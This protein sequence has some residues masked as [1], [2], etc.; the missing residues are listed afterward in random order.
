M[1]ERIDISEV[2]TQHEDPR[3]VPAR[4]RK[5]G[6]GPATRPHLREELPAHVRRL[7]RARLA[8]ADR[9]VQAPLRAPVRQR[10]P[11][12]GHDRA[13]ARAP[14][15]L[16][17]FPSW[18]PIALVVVV[19]VGAA[20]RGRQR[21]RIGAE[22]DHGPQGAV[23]ITHTTT[24]RCQA[25]G[26]PKPTPSRCSWCRRDRLRLPRERRRRE[27]DQRA[28]FTTGQT[29]PTETAPLLL[30]LGNASV[31]MKVDGKPVPVAA[32]ATAIRLRVT[33]RRVSTLPS[34]RSRRCP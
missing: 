7:P 29:I 19:I 23:A 31:Q 12:G 11:S 18:A 6:M 16:A 20:V 5:R 25:R 22:L 32:S 34:P 15:P 9:R 26:P 24:S 17:E 1:R 33:P 28:E 13:R 3:K 2:E 10:D 8:D 4:D 14:A 27:A 21:Y 30:T